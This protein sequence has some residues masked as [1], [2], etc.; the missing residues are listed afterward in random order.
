MTKRRERRRDKKWGDKKGRVERMEY[1][2][3]GGR[4]RK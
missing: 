1:E 2:K 4:E 3:K